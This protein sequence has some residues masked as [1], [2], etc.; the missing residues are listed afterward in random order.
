M[1]LRSSCLDTAMVGF[2]P[3]AILR[4]I[5]SIPRDRLTDPATDRRSAGDGPCDIIIHASCCCYQVIFAGCDD[6]DRFTT[7]RMVGSIAT[8]RWVTK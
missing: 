8:A 7:V 3:A 1:R 5:H 6:R 4:N 2:W